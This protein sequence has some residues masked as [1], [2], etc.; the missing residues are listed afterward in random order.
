MPVDLKR[1]PQGKLGDRSN[2]LHKAGEAVCDMKGDFW[3]LDGVFLLSMK[4]I[5]PGWCGG[6]LPAD[7]MDELKNTGRYQAH[8][9]QLTAQPVSGGKIALRIANF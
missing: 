4:Q 9:L 7:I 3:D 6:E 5:S 1:Q 2:K 8:G